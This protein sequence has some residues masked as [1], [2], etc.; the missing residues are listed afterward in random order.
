MQEGNGIYWQHQGAHVFWPIGRRLMPGIYGTLQRIWETERPFELHMPTAIITGRADVIFDEAGGEV[1]S[2]AIVDYRTSTDP[3][4]AEDYGL[5]LDPRP[6]LAL[7]DLALLARW[8]PLRPAT[9]QSPPAH[10]R[11][12]PNS[13]SLTQG[14]SFTPVQDRPPPSKEGMNVM[15]SRA[16]ITTSTWTEATRTA[17][18]A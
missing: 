18:P 13:G 2:L 5:Q 11:R 4:A 9:P 6:S 16:G 7:R 15:N 1:M 8:R 17:G 12:R 10:P 14:Y 3:E